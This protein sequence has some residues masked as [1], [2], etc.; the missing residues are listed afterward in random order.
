VGRERELV[1]FEMR[2]FTSPT[3]TAKNPGN[4][5][6]AIELDHLHYNYCSIHSA[7]RAPRTMEARISDYVCSIE[8][9]VGLL[10]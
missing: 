5:E 6:A 7:H 10:K 3:L 4:R 2:R 9:L 8:E 1:K